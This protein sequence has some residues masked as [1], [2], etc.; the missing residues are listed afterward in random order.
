MQ[1]PSLSVRGFT[2][3]ELMIVVAIVAILASIAYPSYAESVR[4]GRRAQARAALVELLQQ[5]ERYNTQRNTY[6]AFSNSNGTTT[7][8]SAS[9]TFKVYSG[10]TPTQPA[11]WI[12]A[13]QCDA[14][15]AGGTAP[16]IAS[17][18]KLTAS[19]TQADPR[20]TDL[21]LTS[22]GIKD[23]TLGTGLTDK[24]ICWP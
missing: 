16:D 22:T 9:T 14:A 3:I 19:P 15:V 12:K 11:Y 21:I 4:K 6:L 7:P 1:K 24:K 17:C 2:L 13:E 20:V 10:D 18:V 23:C 5:Q 8:A